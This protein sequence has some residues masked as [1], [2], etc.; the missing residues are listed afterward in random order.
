[1]Q[2]ILTLLLSVVLL[3]LTVGC[4]DGNDAASSNG[5]SSVGSQNQTA[6]AENNSSSQ[7]ESLPAV[8]SV[9]STSSEEETTVDDWKTHPEDFKLIALTYDDAPSFSNITDN[10]TVRIINAINRY[11]GRGTLFV[12]GGTLLSNGNSLLRYAVQNGFELGNHTHSHQ[13]VSTS[14][15]GKNWTALENYEDFARCQELVKKQLG[16]DMKFLRPAGVHANDAL[17]E[18]AENLGLPC[19]SGNSIQAVSDYRSDT[20]PEMIVERVLNNA[21]DGAII[22]LHGNNN[23]TAEATERLCEILYNDGYR[24]CT[25]SELFEL[26]GVDYGTLPNGVMIYG[27]DPETGEVITKN[28]Y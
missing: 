12:V 15:I 16:V 22:L 4:G 28:R 24:F 17:Y 25:V 8:S 5:T 14:E 23:R 6:S 18:A 10:P 27:I 2:R 21:F 26:K 13:S 1:M 7:S 3:V 19:V 11:D 9:D 20:T